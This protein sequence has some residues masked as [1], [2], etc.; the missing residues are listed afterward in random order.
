MPA[1]QTIE[2]FIERSAKIHN[3]KYDYSSVIYKNNTTKVKIVCP[4]HGPFLVIP[5]NHSTHGSGCAICGIGAVNYHNHTIK[6]R[7]THEEFLIRAKNVHGDRYDYSMCTYTG[8]KVKMPIICAKHGIFYQHA[9]NHINLK[10]NCG[11]CYNETKI[12]R[13]GV[14]GYCATFFQT[15]PERKDIP[16]II[17]VARMRHKND[18]FLKIGITVKDSVKKRYYSKT[19]NGTIITPLIEQQESLYSA[20]LKEAQLLATLKPFRYFPNRKFG[21]YTECFKINKEVISFLESYFNI[22]MSNIL[23]NND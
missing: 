16:A 22:N 5:K 10:R 17:Y 2:Q 8:G 18:D 6:S 23:E 20:F 12:G 15:Y 19:K 14:S 9:E 13:A 3:N 1:R 21:G 7:I 4:K 11:K